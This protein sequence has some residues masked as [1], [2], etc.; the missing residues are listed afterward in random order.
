MIAALEGMKLFFL[1]LCNNLKTLC[2][3]TK[4][5]ADKARDQYDNFLD[6]SKQNRSDFKDFNS[7]N[8]RLDDFIMGNFPNMKQYSEFL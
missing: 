7:I 2:I 6:I 8:T 5:Q 4:E 3:I 1:R